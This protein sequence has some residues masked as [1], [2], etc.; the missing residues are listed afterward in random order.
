MF[1]RLLLLSLLVS[2]FSYG[3]EWK[4]LFNGNDLTGWEVLGGKADFKVEDN[5]I[6]GYAVKGTPNTFLATKQTFKDFVLELE[7]FV[8][9]PLNSG[10]Q[11]RSEVNKKG[12][13]FGYQVEVDPA[14]PD[15]SGGIYDEARR[16]WLYY[17]EVNPSAKDYFRVGQWN[18]YRVEA[19]GNIIRTFINGNPVSY[20]VDEMTSEGFIALQVHSISNRAKDGM[21]IKFRNIRINTSSPQLSH[22]D[23]TPVVNLLKNQLSPQE[24]YQGFELL[25]NGNDLSGW[26]EAKGTEEPTTRWS[27]ND[28]I[29][30][31]A[32]SD[33]SETG[34][35]IVTR[36]NYSSFELV[37][38]FNFSKGAN[39][40]I[41]YFVDENYISIGKSAIGL[42][43]QI[44]DDERHP[45]G[46]MG[47]LGNRTLAS[48][49]DLIPSYRL[50]SWSNGAPDRWN[51]GKVIVKPDNTVQHWLNGRKVLEYT[52]GDN[53]YKVLV[54]HSKYKNLKG[55]GMAESGPILL[56]DHGDQVSFK[57][58]KI[59]RLK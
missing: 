20:L 34:N 9:D 33:G 44:L 4:S 50:S 42:E 16:G 36:Q 56:Q 39:S 2:S 30:S 24:I 21:H 38:D 12:S 28:G 55:F 6:V 41:K 15:M 43:Y 51:T 58:V 57:N 59:R 14:N 37:F 10:I 31:V 47:V 54:A 3:Q 29:L 17:P 35:D 5:A 18:V 46:K 11:I 19:V 40:G 7:V 23:Q 53:I 32:S 52:R 22:S 25:F 27:V 48:L 45:D 1:K 49:Y 8:A 26:R 13:V